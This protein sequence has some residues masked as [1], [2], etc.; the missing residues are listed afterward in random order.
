MHKKEERMFLVMEI[1]PRGQIYLYGEIHCKEKIMERQLELWYNYYHNEKLRHLFLEHCYCATEFLNIWMRS[2][3]DDI[4]EML[5]EIALAPDF[6]YIKDFFR[7]IK[8]NCSETVFC[9]TTPVYPPI[10]E[11]YIQY[12]EDNNQTGSDK[13]LQAQELMKKGKRLYKKYGGEWD[14]GYREKNMTENFI[15]EFEKLNSES[16]MGIYGAMHIMLEPLEY[17]GDVPCLCYQL[18]E[19]YGEAVHYEDLSYLID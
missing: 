13:Y 2:D 17:F 1:N 7:T 14:D 10:G 11:K 3:S 4:L 5:Y 9:S 8:K 6:P 12:L 15:R 16:V 18:K 19:R